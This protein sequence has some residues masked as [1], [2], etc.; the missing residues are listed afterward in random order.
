MFEP[1][2][3]TVERPKHGQRATGV[4]RGV[5]ASQA[6]SPI[7]P[8]VSSRCPDLLLVETTRWRIC[9]VTSAGGPHA[10]G[11]GAPPPPHIELPLRERR[12]RRIGRTRQIG[13]GRSGR[14]FVERHRLLLSGVLSRVGSKRA[15][16]KLTKSF[17]YFNALTLSYPKRSV[18]YRVFRILFTPVRLTLADPLR[19][20]PN[21]QRRFS[22]DL[23]EHGLA[24]RDL[25]GL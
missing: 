12:S 14:R 9:P 2:G 19:H 21:R 4:S 17:V 18:N 25:P 15:A 11:R 1:L 24:A 5:L 3:P 8:C 23:Q 20:V 7:F 6:T 16:S 22:T 13:S 10:F